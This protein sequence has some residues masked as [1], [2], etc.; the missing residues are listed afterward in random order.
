MF[1]SAMR[2]APFV[3]ILLVFVFQLANTLGHSPHGA[4]GAPCTGLV[5]HHDD[6]ADEQ[7]GQHQAVK[8]KAELGHPVRH[9]PGGVGPVPGHPEGPEQL[10]GLPQGRGPRR[11]QIGLEHHVAEHR[12]EKEQKGITEPLGGHPAGRGLAAGAFK[13]CPQL[14]EQLTPSAEVVAEKLVPAEDG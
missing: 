5:E 13:V 11:H 8:A 3:C 2:K 10:N 9:R 12:Q 6:E 4:E 1:S 7:R 14:A